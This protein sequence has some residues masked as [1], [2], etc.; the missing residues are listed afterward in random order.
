MH[1][2]SQSSQPSHHLGGSSKKGNQPDVAA[3]EKNHTSSGKPWSTPSPCS[4][5]L[6]AAEGSE[7]FVKN[8][9]CNLW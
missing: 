6:Q 9:V 4:N 7:A 2:R 3:V 8:E 1:G 5:C